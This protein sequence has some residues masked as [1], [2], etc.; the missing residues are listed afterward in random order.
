MPA[1]LYLYQMLHTF[2]HLFARHLPWGTFCEVILG[3]MGS[4][5]LEAL[6]SIC[7]CWRM[8]ETG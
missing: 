5:H 2:R 7:R 1:L 4:H 8:D 3:F 6:T